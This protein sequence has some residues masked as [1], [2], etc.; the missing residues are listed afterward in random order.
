MTILAK[1][2]HQPQNIYPTQEQKFRIRSNS[3]RQGF[4]MHCKTK[5]NSM[6][7]SECYSRAL[8][9]LSKELTP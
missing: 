4:V 3:L 2:K 9:H 8:Q 6:E 1:V 7:K 5:F